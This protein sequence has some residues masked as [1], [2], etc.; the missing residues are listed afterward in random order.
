MHVRL[1]VPV[2]LHVTHLQGSGHNTRTQSALRPL[3]ELLTSRGP[4][5]PFPLRRLVFCSPIHSLDHR[6]LQLLEA[7]ATVHTASTDD[8]ANG[9]RPSTRLQDT[10][11][12]PVRYP[13]SAPASSSTIVASTY[14]P[15]HHFIW[16][17]ARVVSRRVVAT[18]RLSTA[19]L[20]IQA[21]LRLHRVHHLRSHPIQHP[22]QSSQNCISR[23]A[24]PTA[25]Q[26]TLLMLAIS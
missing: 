24:N 21:I 16:F 25:G 17:L 15:G 18:P 7:P 26:A 11:P 9:R 6:Y 13:H 3:L 19:T 20:P 12:Q 10:L 22:I 8:P 2:V 14:T 23:R 1:G 5:M 4:H